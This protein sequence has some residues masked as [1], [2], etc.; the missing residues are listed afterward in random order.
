[1]RKSDTLTTGCSLPAGLSNAY[2]IVTNFQTTYTNVNLLRKFPHNPSA[3]ISKCLSHLT[4]ISSAFQALPTAASRIP[5]LLEN[6]KEQ[7]P[8]GTW[9]SKLKTN[10]APAMKPNFQIPQLLHC[11]SNYSAGHNY[12]SNP[13][14]E[15]CSEANLSTLQSAWCSQ[16]VPE[17]P[18]PLLT[19]VTVQKSTYFTYLVS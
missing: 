16:G 5:F 2:K 11:R 8:T 1:M 18:A 15:H 10:P 12:P 9:S 4:R 19:R 7:Q 14:L 17:W 6:Q 13:R 3:K